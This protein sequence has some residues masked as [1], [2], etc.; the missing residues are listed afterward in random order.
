MVSV[1]F[2]LQHM[3]SLGNAPGTL[4]HRRVFLS[5][6]GCSADVFRSNWLAV[7]IKFYL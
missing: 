7:L 2:V 4:E 3:A 5:L 1:V 6:N